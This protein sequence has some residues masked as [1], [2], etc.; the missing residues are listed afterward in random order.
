MIER[1]DDGGLVV[2]ANSFGDLI[3]AVPLKKYSN[4]KRRTQNFGLT[5]QIRI[6]L[7]EEITSASGYLGGGISLSY[8]SESFSFYQLYDVFGWMYNEKDPLLGLDINLGIHPYHDN[9]TN[10]GLFAMWDLTGRW[11]GTSAKILTGPVFMTYRQNIMVRLNVKIPMV[12][13]GK[14][15]QLSK[16]LFMNVGIGF[17]F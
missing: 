1:Q 6:P 13:N 7:N 10:T 12:E 17:V 14:K 4:F 11:Q 5:P 16:G 2:K 15:A 9:T 3:L 8:S